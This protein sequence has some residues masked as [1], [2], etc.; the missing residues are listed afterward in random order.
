MEQQCGTTVRGYASIDLQV[1]Y[2]LALQGSRVNAPALP[3]ILLK[4]IWKLVD[5]H[6]CGRLSDPDIRAVERI[7]GRPYVETGDFRQ[8]RVRVCG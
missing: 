6:I 3:A 7:C 1:A 8:A 4:E 2:P 5:P